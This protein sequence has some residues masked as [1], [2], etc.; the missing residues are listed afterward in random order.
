MTD[1]IRR[2]LLAVTETSPLERLWESLTEHVADT[3]VEVIAVFV[4]DD[5]WRRA[6]SLP[7]TREISR[8]S[9]LQAAFTRNRARE[10]GLHAADRVRRQLEQLAGATKLQLVFETLPEDDETQI[11][12]LVTVECDVLI[13]PSGLEGQPLFVE[14]A[15]R[16]ERV[17]VVEVEDGSQ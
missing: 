15:R 8:I 1:D 14:L 11:H 10:V 12:S 9:G 2:V 7:F 13:A 5:A 4:R 16:Y 6:A 3:R 17:V